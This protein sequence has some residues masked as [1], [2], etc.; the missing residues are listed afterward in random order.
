MNSVLF[1]KKK[2]L[3]QNKTNN[4]NQ[5]N[6][7]NSRKNILYKLKLFQKNSQTDQIIDSFIVFCFHLV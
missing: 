4:I 7:I 1:L 3:T 5:L 2:H 6:T